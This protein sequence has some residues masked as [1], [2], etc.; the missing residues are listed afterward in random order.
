MICG[1][2]GIG[3]EG[4]TH[5]CSQQHT[6]TAQKANARTT[7]RR[8]HA[9]VLVAYSSSQCRLSLVSSQLRN[10]ALL[11]AL[12]MTNHTNQDF[13]ILCCTMDKPGASSAPAHC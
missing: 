3:C 13:T 11:N 5:R 2:Q 6:T 4:R 8:N 9:N 12:Q 10:H 1:E 7:E